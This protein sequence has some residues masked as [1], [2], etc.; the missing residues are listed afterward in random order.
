MK[1]SEMT[2]EKFDEIL[3]T[4]KFG[5]LQ[6]PERHGYEG[7][8]DRCLFAA[9]DFDGKQFDV[10]FENGS[11]DIYGYEGIALDDTFEPWCVS[12]D[13]ERGT[14]EQII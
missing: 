2:T 14:W 11:Y 6:Y 9:Y 10:L 12:I 13:C 8:S 4:L 5:L 1:A 3:P 7:A